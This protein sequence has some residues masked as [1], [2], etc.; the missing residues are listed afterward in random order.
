MVLIS[1]AMMVGAADSPVRYGAVPARPAHKLATRAKGSLIG[2]FSSDDYPKEAMQK[3]ETGTVK[4]LLA[5]GADGRIS[6][7]KVTLSSLS[8]SLDAATCRILSER[9]RFKPALDRAGHAVTD[10]FSQRITWKIPEPE[11][12]AVADHLSRAI[13]AQHA[14]GRAD[15]K[16]W[17]DK[18]EM[19]V[20]ATTCVAWSTQAKHATARLPAEVL[21]PYRATLTLQSLVGEGVPVVPNPAMAIRGAARLRIDARGRVTGCQPIAEASLNGDDALDLCNHSDEARFTALPASEKDRGDRTMV[22]V[23]TILFEPGDQGG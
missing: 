9:A 22:R 2:L 19:P 15:C 20:D 4:V 7:C 21:A 6:A 1:L 18:Q 8:S 14:D 3:L 10:R 23:R 17:T 16:M 5:I 11:A 12:E 13:V